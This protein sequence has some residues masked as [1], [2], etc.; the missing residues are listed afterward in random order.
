MKKRS[1]WQEVRGIL[2]G[3]KAAR[4]IQTQ[5]TAND[6]NEKCERIC[7]WQ[8]V[9]GIVRGSVR[10]AR[11]PSS[12][13]VHLVF[14]PIMKMFTRDGDYHHCDAVLYF[15]HRAHYDFQS[16]GLCSDYKDVPIQMVMIIIVMLQWTWITGHGIV[17]LQTGVVPSKIIYIYMYWQYCQGAPAYYGMGITRK[18]CV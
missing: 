11:W 17:T 7:K 9:R 18:P 12:C 6:R 1:K 4:E 16:P 14:A 5:I 15:Y 2:G 10:T 13:R 8:E 3:L